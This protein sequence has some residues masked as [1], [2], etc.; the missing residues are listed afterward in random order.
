MQPR[1]GR[2]GIWSRE[3]LRTGCARRL[4]VCGGPGVAAGSAPRRSRTRHGRPDR[5][6]VPSKT[7]PSA[8]GRHGRRPRA[9]WQRW[10]RPEGVTYRW[11]ASRNARTSSSVISA[12]AAGMTGRPSRVS[13][14]LPVSGS[15]RRPAPSAT[16]STSPGRSPRWSRRA[17]PIRRAAGIRRG[18]RR[19]S[20]RPVRWPFATP[21]R[22]QDGE[23]E[24]GGED[25]ADQD[26][27][28]EHA[29]QIRRVQRTALTIVEPVTRPAPR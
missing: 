23:P 8:H 16:T 19:R 2:R 5:V 27:A 14:A 21:G 9:Q 25:P 3:T 28:G 13:R 22:L 6:S 20:G 29:H 26:D 7:A 11:P 4:P 15:T 10:C 18:G 1:R 12:P 17:G 24:I